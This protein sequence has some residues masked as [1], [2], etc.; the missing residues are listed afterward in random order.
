VA[1]GDSLIS[2]TRL[3]GG[4][5]LPREWGWKMWDIQDS[6][7][8]LHNLMCYCLVFVY[9]CWNR[10]G[11]SFSLLWKTGSPRTYAE[12]HACVRER[13]S[14]TP[15]RSEANTRHLLE[16][17]TDS[18]WQP[19]GDALSLSLSSSL[20]FTHLW[21]SPSSAERWAIW[22]WPRSRQDDGLIS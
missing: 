12:A 22:G 14:F 21:P 7:G 11:F 2:L 18:G 5:S 1:V 13:A 9:I 4:C 6:L 8:S 10:G 16:L 19:D 20:S 17:I 3:V 15:P